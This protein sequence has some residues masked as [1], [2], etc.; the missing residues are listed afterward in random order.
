M[1]GAAHNLV[2]A[3]NSSS[4]NSSSSSSSSHNN[5]SNDCH[6]TRGAP[7]I[8]H[9]RPSTTLTKCRALESP[10]FTHQLGKQIPYNLGKLDEDFSLSYELKGRQHRAYEL[11]DFCRISKAELACQQ[12]AELGVLLLLGRARRSQE[13]LNGNLARR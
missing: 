5:D 8:S 2:E 13:V 3:H 4:S 6:R 7:A 10:V 9:T 12:V 1:Q 11:F